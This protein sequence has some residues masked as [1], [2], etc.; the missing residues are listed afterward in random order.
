[1]RQVLCEVHAVKDDKDTPA[2]PETIAKSRSYDKSK[3]RAAAVE[4]RRLEREAKKKSD[5]KATSKKK[6][7]TDPTPSTSKKG[8]T[9]SQSTWSSD[10]SSSG[11][12]DD[13]DESDPSE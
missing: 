8:A 4:A 13:D 3:A 7:A 5:P 2:S 1:M 10:Y 9:P 6:T 12:E 11:G